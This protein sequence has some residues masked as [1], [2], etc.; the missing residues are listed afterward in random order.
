MTARDRSLPRTS[1]GRT[2]R[3]VVVGAGPGGLAAAM[4]LAAA[5]ASVTVFEKD[6]VVGGRTRTITAPGGYRFDIGPTFFLYPRILAEIF[7]ACGERLEDHVDAEAARSA[8]PPRVRR[9]RRDPRDPGP[10][11]PS[12]RDRQDLARPTRRMS[13]ASSTTTAPSS[14]AFRPVLEQAFCHPGAICVAGDA[15]GFAAAAAASRASTAT[16]AGISPTRACASPSRS[17]RNTSACRRSAARAC[18]RSCRFLEYEHGVFHPIGGCGAVSEAMAALA[19]RMGVDIRL[20]TPVERV[21]Y[22][23]GAAD[24]RRGRRRDGLGRRGGG[25]RRFRPCHAPARAGGACAARWPDRKIDRARLSCSTF[26]LYLGIEGD[27]GRPRAPHHLPGRA[28]TSATSARSAAASCRRSRPSTCSMP[29]H[30]SRHG[31]GGPHQPLRARAGA[32]PALPASTGALRGAALPRAR[33]RAPRGPR[34]R[35]TS[36]AASASSAW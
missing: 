25:Q 15:A 23:N 3:V 32:E 17:R 34:A 30:R 28:T 27:V 6:D 22:R 21:L 11:A 2:P 7:E 24:R 36:R 16:C 14:Q 4:L 20:G 10:R 31:A 18:S 35:A 29:A 19:R 33:P 13:A 8:I 12:S 26:M 1:M 5:G 9:R